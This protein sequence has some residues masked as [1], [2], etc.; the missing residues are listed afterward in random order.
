[1]TVDI[2]YRGLEFTVKGTYHGEER[3]VMYYSD[4][5]GYPGAPAE[6]EIESVKMEDIE[7]IDFLDE[8]Y[9]VRYGAKGSDD[10]YTSALDE[11]ESLCIEQAGEAEDYS[12][13]EDDI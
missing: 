2:I 3:A 8:L 4:R 11:I 5:S 6:F 9:E 7:M 13:E 1:M 12:R 10:S